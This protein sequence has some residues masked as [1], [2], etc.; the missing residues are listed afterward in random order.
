MHFFGDYA[1]PVV[2]FIIMVGIGLII[3]CL[4]FMKKI[5]DLTTKS[6]GVSVLKEKAWPCLR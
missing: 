3:S 5:G 4:M 6:S 2:L 1:L